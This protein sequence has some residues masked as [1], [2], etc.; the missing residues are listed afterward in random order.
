MRL[1]VSRDCCWAAAEAELLGFIVGSVE[2]EPPRVVIVLVRV[3][4]GMD[5]RCRVECAVFG[6]NAYCLVDRRCRMAL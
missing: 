5:R 1:L 3:G 6:G 4:E 2:G